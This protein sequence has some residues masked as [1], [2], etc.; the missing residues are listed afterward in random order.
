MSPS[1]SLATAISKHQCLDPNRHANRAIEN[2][3]SAGSYRHSSVTVTLQG[4]CS[5]V[6]ISC[7]GPV[8]VSNVTLQY[9]RSVDSRGTPFMF[10]VRVSTYAAAGCLLT[11]AMAIAAKPPRRW[12]H[13]PVCLQLGEGHRG[14]KGQVVEGWCNRSDVLGVRQCPR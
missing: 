14:P 13:R 1:P 5:R 11:G 2:S 3:P 6:P 4:Q 8:K 10:T 9:H 12:T 7:L